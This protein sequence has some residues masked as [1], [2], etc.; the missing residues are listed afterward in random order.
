MLA[1]LGALS[2]GLVVAVVVG[3]VGGDLVESMVERSTGAQD[4]GRSLPGFGGHLD[5][6]DSLL[7]VLPLAV[8]LA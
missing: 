4:A 1:V 7:L 3:S 6:V 5:R 2:W 8:V